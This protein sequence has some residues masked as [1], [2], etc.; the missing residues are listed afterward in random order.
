[1]QSVLR[2]VLVVAVLLAFATLAVLPEYAQTSNGVIAGVIVDNSGAVVLKATVEATSTDRGG[3][4]HVTETDSSGSYRVESLLPGTYSLVV[5]KAGFAEIRVSGLDVKASLT[6]TFNGTLELAGQTTS[7]LVEASTGQELQT[8][9]GDLSASISSSEVHDLPILGLNPIALVLTEPGVQDP[10]S[11]RGLSNGVNFSVNGNRPRGNN[12]LIDGQDNNDNAIAG[13]AF[14]P[15]NLEAI[16]EV[17]ILTNSYSAEFGRGGGSVTNVI[18][19]GG[20]NNFHGSAWEL[21]NNSALATARHEDL[22]AGCE[23]T[24]PPSCHPVSVDNT[25]GFAFGGP[26]IRNKLFVFGSSQWDRFRSTNNGGPLTAPTANGVAELQALGSPNANFLIAAFA[27]LVAQPSVT[28]TLIPLGSAT[29]ATSTTP[30]SADRGNVEF[31]IVQRAG[32]AEVQNDRQWDV[33]LDFIA[34]ERDTL[35]ARYYR[36]DSSLA[37][38]LFNFPRSLVPFDSQ[39]GGPSQSAAA[40]WTHTISTKAVNELRVSYTNINFAFAPTAATSANPLFSSPAITIG[41]IGAGTNPF[42]TLGF[43]TALPQG[44]GHKS[45]QYQDALSMTLGRHTRKGGVDVNHLSVVDQIPFNSR[46]TILFADSS[47]QS[48]DAQL[49]AGMGTCGA[50]DCTALANFVDNF[51]GVSGQ[52]AKVFGNPTLQ[53]FVTTYAPY[54]QD[55]WRLRENLSIDL[56]LRYEYYGTPEN[57]LPFPALNTSAGFGLPGVGLSGFPGVYAS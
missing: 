43:P 49:A 42:P 36:D 9:S 15:S 14:Q 21:A 17:T 8:Q 35:T 18:Y 45:Y 50:I 20:S 19:K 40:F 52:I 57:V 23:T 51:T 31:G 26:I 16:S 24:T 56:G 3:A 11:G 7:I 2:T 37:P 32:I 12:F 29:P 47:G 55:T 28:P 27:G 33:R 1:M 34:S 41:G 6:T 30:A 4:P 5:K 53:P 39:Q 46:G 25:F 44:R 38:D 54:I 22:F 10:G 13:Q 48:S